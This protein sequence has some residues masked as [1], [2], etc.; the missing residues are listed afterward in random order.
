MIYV[1]LDVKIFWWRW[2]SKY[3]FLSKNIEKTSENA[4]SWRSKGVHISNLKLWHGA[5]MSRLRYYAKKIWIYL[6]KSPLVVEQ[7]NYS[8]KIVN[9]YIVYDLNDSPKVPL[10]NFTLKNYLFG[11]TNIVKNSD[12]RK[13]VYNGYGIA[14]DG[15]GEWSFGNSYARNVVINGSFG[16]SEKNI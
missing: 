7:N 10:R 9:A 8:T 15:K 4:I 14:F 12:K 13:Y 1:I 2:F 11:A 16:T 6:N 3:I 5:F